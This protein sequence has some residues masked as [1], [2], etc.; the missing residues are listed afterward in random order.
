M[1]SAT[2]RSFAAGAP[3]ARVVR[4][5]NLGWAGRLSHYR[6]GKLGIADLSVWAARFPDEVPTVNGEVEWIGLT[7]ADL[8]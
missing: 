8:D 4:L 2:P 7:L 3:S 6:A 1:P 5:D